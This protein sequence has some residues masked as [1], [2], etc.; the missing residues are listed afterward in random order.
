MQSKPPFERE[1]KGGCKGRKDSFRGRKGN[2]GVGGGSRSQANGYP[3]DRP[4][5]KVIIC[6]FLLENVR[7]PQIIG[8]EGADFIRLVLRI[9]AEGDHRGGGRIR[10]KDIGSETKEKSHRGPHEP[11]LYRAVKRGNPVPQ[12]TVGRRRKTHGRNKFRK[13]KATGNRAGGQAGG[14]R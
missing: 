10:D 8:T 4:M 5:S 3:S 11:A 9:S 14:R 1:R 6:K 7:D 2:K 12:E 13:G